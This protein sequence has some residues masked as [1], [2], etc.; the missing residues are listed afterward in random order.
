MVLLLVCLFLITSVTSGVLNVM[1]PSFLSILLLL[2]GVLL[3][4]VFWLIP[5][6]PPEI[7]ANILKFFQCGNYRMV[8]ILMTCWHLHRLLEHTP[9]PQ[10]TECCRRFRSY[11]QSVME[12]E[13]PRVRQRPSGDT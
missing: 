9:L 11:L 8:S 10:S 6:H 7:A 1:E 2:F 5:T 3:Q 12:A 4:V 13:W